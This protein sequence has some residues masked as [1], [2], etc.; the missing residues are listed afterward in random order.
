M[1]NQEKNPAR[2]NHLMELFRNNACTRAEMEELFRLMRQGDGS[3]LL[4]SLQ[5]QW[6][7]AK[8]GV[9]T[10]A[11]NWDLLFQLMISQSRELDAADEGEAVS[12]ERELEVVSAG[13]SVM[14]RRRRMRRRW[15]VA[16]FCFLFLLGGAAIVFRLLSVSPTAPSR[17]LPMARRIKNDVQP[18]GNK[19]VLTL[20][21]GSSIVLDSASDGTLSQQGSTKVIKLS[22]GRLAYQPAHGAADAGPLYNIISTPRGGQYQIVLQ[23]GSKVWLNAGSSLRF[24]TA[25]TGEVREVQLSGE[26][27]FEVSGDARRP[28]T[29]A[30]FTREPGKGEE[31]QKVKVLGTQFNIMAYADEA[32]VKTTLLEGAVKIDGT[33]LKPGEQAQLSHDRGS[34]LQVIADADVDAA[35]AWKN[36]YFDFN[37][38]DIQT[39]MRQL[40]RWYDVEVSFRGNGSRDK[41]FFGGIQRNL[42]LTSIFNILE[43]SG[44][45]FSIDG[46][47]VVVDL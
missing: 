22:S 39:I 32:L 33:V 46:K 7:E 26:A 40:S 19:A 36:G 8:A 34:A 13:A 47:K 3:E 2:L 43:K 38:A 27:Y 42:P 16:S 18:G 35:V 30:V 12:P 5:R 25:F 11:P 4:Q 23:D 1:G 37:K 41:L 29:V 10:D 17:A 24:P 15:A 31:L 14:G 9:P 45:Q 21:D 20:A 44:V 6:D 28:F